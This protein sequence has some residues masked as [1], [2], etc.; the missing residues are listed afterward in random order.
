MEKKIELNSNFKDTVYQVNNGTPINIPI[1]LPSKEQVQKY[2]DIFQMVSILSPFEMAN[3]NNSQTNI[4]FTN[5]I[6]VKIN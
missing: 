2:G 1:T 5:P 4:N 3:G 6:Q